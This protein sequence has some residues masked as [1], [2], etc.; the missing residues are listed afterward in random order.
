MWFTIYF[1]SNILSALA[2][3]E[4]YEQAKEPVVNDGKITVYAQKKVGQAETAGDKSKIATL[5]FAIP[6]TVRK[7]ESF[8][9]AVPEANYSNGVETETF[10]L[11]DQVVPYTAAYDIT[12]GQAIIGRSVDFAIT[13]VAGEKIENITL[14]DGSGTVLNSNVFTTAGRKTVYAMDD[15]GN[16]S[17]NLDLAVCKNGTDGDGSPY[18]VQNNA[19]KNGAT[20]KSITW[21]SAIESSK[22]AAYLK[23]AKSAENVASAETQSGKSEYIT[24]VESDSGEAYRMNSVK[25]EGLTPD[26]T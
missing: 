5:K 24:F 25:L 8:T 23:Y 14:Y 11:A 12:A 19:S 7:G 17:W 13:N 1:K 3:G 4:C 2:Y 6:E 15:E 26:T 22:E 21:L 9:Y 16:R 18:G 20:E 10:S